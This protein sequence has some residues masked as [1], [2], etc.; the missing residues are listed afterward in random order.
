MGAKSAKERDPAVTTLMDQIGSDKWPRAKVEKLYDIFF[1]S[2]S[3]TG[4]L[5]LATFKKV[6]QSKEMQQVITSISFDASQQQTSSDD[7]EPLFRAFDSDGSGSVEF[8]EFAMACYIFDT[9]DVAEKM[10]FVFKM[11]DKSGSG[12][13][14]REQMRQNTSAMS[15]SHKADQIFDAVDKKKTG[16]ITGQQFVDVMTSNLAARALVDPDASLL[17][18]DRELIEKSGGYS[19][20]VLFLNNLSQKTLIPENDEADLLLTVAERLQN[21]IGTPPD[22]YRYFCNKKQLD[23]NKTLKENG[24]VLPAV[25]R[26]MPK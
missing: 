22:Y 21:K 1:K 3:K 14:T 25:I 17:Q 7:F 13:L 18:H 23:L 19:S 5:D 4:S 9:H 10:K 2:A 11:I 20:S 8:A 24:V 26:L 16:T 12:S 15:F 6:M